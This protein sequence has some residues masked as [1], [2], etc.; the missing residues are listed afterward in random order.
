MAPARSWHSCRT[1]IQAQLGRNQEHRFE[2]APRGT[3]PLPNPQRTYRATHQHPHTPQASIGSHPKAPGRVR[4]PS[5]VT[6]VALVLY[7]PKRRGRR[8]CHHKSA[9]PHRQLLNDDQ[10]PRGQKRASASINWLVRQLRKTD[11]SDVLVRT[12]WHGEAGRHRQLCRMS[13]K[14]RNA[15]N[16]AYR[17]HCRP[18]LKW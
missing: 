13:S 3:E 15:W 16:K 1:A 4:C 14:T 12:Y 17:G 8:C 10:G 2:L 5:C 6:R 18:A 7:R 11:P 9:A